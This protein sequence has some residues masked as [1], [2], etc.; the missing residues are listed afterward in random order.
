ME[1]PIFE[2]VL[3]GLDVRGSIVG[4]RHDLEEVFELHRRGLTRVEHAERRLDDV[5]RA[6]EEILDGTAPAPRLVFRMTPVDHASANEDA[7]PSAARHAS[8]SPRSNGPLRRATSRPAS[9]PGA[10]PRAGGRTS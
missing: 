7:R 4:T 8:A 10:R 9:Q 1:I 3:G 6:I 5:N 2:T